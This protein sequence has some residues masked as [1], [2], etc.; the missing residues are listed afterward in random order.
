MPRSS[1]RFHIIIDFLFNETRPFVMAAEENCYL[2]F[3]NSYKIRRQYAENT[4]KKPSV[5]DSVNYNVREEMKSTG[6]D[7]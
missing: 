5:T 1:R 3:R 7:W 2:H 4:L 6:H